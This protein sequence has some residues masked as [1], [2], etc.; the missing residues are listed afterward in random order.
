MSD[1]PNEITIDNSVVVLVDQQPWVAFSVKSIDAGLLVN[2][3]T[4]LAA[5]LADPVRQTVPLS[6]ACGRYVDWYAVAPGTPASARRCRRT[7]NTP[8]RSGSCPDRSTR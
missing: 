5:T 2:N 3:L 6:R 8:C 1:N 7:A 4:G